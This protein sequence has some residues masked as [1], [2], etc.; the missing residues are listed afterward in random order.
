MKPIVTVT[1]ADCRVDTFRGSG[2]GGQK[3]NKTSSGV[4]VVHEPSGAIG[5]S[6]ATRSQHLNRVDAFRKM[7]TSYKF[8]QW[9]RLETMRRT[10]ELA[11]IE[12][13]VDRMVRDE[14]KV[15][16]HDGRVWVH[17]ATH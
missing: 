17:E 13:E 8:T 14:T 16:Y 12:A 9:I 10:G 2:A 15:E 11:A 5:E 7:A 6:E 3:R 4:R 1:I